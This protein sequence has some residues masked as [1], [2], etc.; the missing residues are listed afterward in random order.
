MRPN[1]YFRACCFQVPQSKGSV[2]TRRHFAKRVRFVTALEILRP[3]AR[4]RNTNKNA[5]GRR[6]AQYCRWFPELI[7]PGAASEEAGASEVACAFPCVFPKVDV[8]RTRRPVSRTRIHCKFHASKYA[9]LVDKTF[10]QYKFA[11]R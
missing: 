10:A 1:D 9:F 6:A 11:K 7:W 8:S 2:R 3:K 5:S 4:P